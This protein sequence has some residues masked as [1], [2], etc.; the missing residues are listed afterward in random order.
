MSYSDSW[1]LA[2][3]L[4]ICSAHPNSSKPV[5]TQLPST[6][7]GSLPDSSRLLSPSG[8]P[9]PAR[10]DVTYAL[11]VETLSNG[12]KRGKVCQLEVSRS[13]APAAE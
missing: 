9:E 10:A 1:G 2:I 6:S 5:A 13:L 3:P 8:T 11:M 7:I 12:D 4:K